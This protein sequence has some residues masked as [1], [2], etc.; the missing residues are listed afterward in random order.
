M[1]SH[2]NLAFLPC[3]WLAAGQ[4]CVLAANSSAGNLQ[5]FTD[6]GHPIEAPPGTRVVEIDAPIS[7]EVELSARLPA[8]SG[9]AAA[10]ARTRLRAGG[11]ALQKR[12]ATAYQGVVYAWSLGIKK[13]PAVVV[14][15]RYVVYGVP[16]ATQAVS[17]IDRYRREHR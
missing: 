15:R 16:D 17:I 3:G 9:R 13:I 10:I 6:G 1:A 4:L 7:L 8:D 11:A 12:F 5:V 2:R 14:D